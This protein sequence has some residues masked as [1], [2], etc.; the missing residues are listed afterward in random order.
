MGRSYH[1]M[2]RRGMRLSASDVGAVAGRVAKRVQRWLRRP[3]LVDERPAE[4]ARGGEEVGAGRARRGRRAVHGA[5]EE[6]LRAEV[7][8][9]DVYAGVMIRAGD[10]GALERLCDDAARACAILW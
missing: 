3:G 9:F 2:R 1:E 5:Q 6:P 8:D 7:D 10:R 4:I